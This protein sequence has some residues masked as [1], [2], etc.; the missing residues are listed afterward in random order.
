VLRRQVSTDGTRKLLLALADGQTIE[1]VIMPMPRTHTICLSSQVGC[2]VGCTF[3]RTGL[4]GFSRNLTLDELMGQVRTAWQELLD[5]AGAHP[6]RAVFMGMGEPL[7]NF[8]NLQRCLQQ[9]SSPR[10]RH[11][12]WRKIQVSTVG[13]PDRLEELGRSRLALP[14][15]SLHAPTQELRDRIMPGARRWP[16]TDLMR[17][18][19]DYPLPDRERITIEYILMEDVNDGVG[20]ARQ[21]SGLLDGIRA[22]VNLIPCNPVPGSPYRSPGPWRIDEF[23][24]SLREGGL[25]AFVRRSLG[26]DIAAACGQLRSEAASGASGGRTP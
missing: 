24:R 6:L 7:L 16:I 10:E 14:A 19:R 12:S 15:V 22:K 11:L 20:H 17:V 8:D 1:T 9:L 13:I 21:L 23:M 26:P 2:P 4:S 3:C 25:T 18:L 5:A